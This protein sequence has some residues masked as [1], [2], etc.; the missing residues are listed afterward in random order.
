MTPN[1]DQRKAM[2]TS[3]VRSREFDDR[4]LELYFADKMPVFDLGKGLIP[5]EIHSSH[6]H[7]PCA[8]GTMIHLRPEDTITASHR[9]HHQAVCRGL[10]LSKLAAELMG[11]KSGYCA[12]KGGHMHIYSQAH[13]F[14]CSGIIAEGMGPAAGVALANKMRK[15]PGIAV[16]YMGEA[17]ANQGAFHEVMNMAGIYKLPYICVIEDNNWG[18]SVNKQASTAVARN[19]DRASAYGVYGEYVEGNDCDAIFEAMA[20]CVERARGGGGSSIL[21]IQTYR[22]KG[23]MLGDTMDYVSKQ[24]LQGLKDCVVDYR[25]KLIADGTMTDAEA[26]AIVAEVK[27]EVDVAIQFGIDSPYPEP[28]DAFNGLFAGTSR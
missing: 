15:Q 20:R 5:G 8:A 16:S 27:Q 28:D 6:G 26:D 11:K 18:V 22:L 3:I 2:Y 1:A 9:P 25:A 4:I 23:H 13:N 19:S 21:E 10:D 24:E 17:A 7:E 12:G 14:S